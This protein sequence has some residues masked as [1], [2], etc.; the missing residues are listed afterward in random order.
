MRA[1]MGDR[2]VTSLREIRWRWAREAARH[3]AISGLSLMQDAAQR[4]DQ[5]PATNGIHFLYLHHVPQNELDDFRRLVSTLGRDYR[6]LSYSE[7]V[8]R[9]AGAEIDDRYVALS[10]DDGLA[11]TLKAADVLSERGISACF[12]LVTSI[13]GVNDSEAV[14]RFSHDRLGLSP[15]KFMEWQD[16]DWLLAS[17]H[18]IGGHTRTHANL[19]LVS[20]ADAASEIEGCF[21]DLRR[22]I[23]APVHFAWP[24]GRFAAFSAHAAATVFQAGFKSCASGERGCHAFVHRSDPQQLCVRRDLVAA[25]WP[26]SHI[27]YFLRR[28][29]RRASPLDNLWPAELAP[30]QATA[31]PTP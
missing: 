15:A 31:G 1:I 30:P 14:A 9:I 6:F 25:S 24:F 11:C 3:A 17:G 12:F 10:F 13:I 29:R 2:F 18:E 23:G 22:Q 4:I 26:A 21:D 28:S 16:I 5:G 20:D 7:A 19:G 8:R 27:R